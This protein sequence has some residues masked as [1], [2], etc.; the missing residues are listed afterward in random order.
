M[1]GGEDMKRIVM[2]HG[3]MLLFLA[4]VLTMVIM[5]GASIKVQAAAKRYVKSLSVK[6]NVTVEKGKKVTVKPT[7]KVAGKA[8]KKV[9]VKS[10]NKNIV[11][12]SYS[13]KNNTIKINGVKKGKATIAVTTKSKNKKG[14][15]ISKKINVKVTTET[16]TTEIPISKFILNKTAETLLIEH[17]NIV[18]D[19]VRDN[20]S[21]F[22]SNNNSNTNA[23]IAPAY[24]WFSNN[25]SDKVLNLI[26]MGYPNNTTEDKTITWISSNPAIAT[27]DGNGGV[28]PVSVGTCTIT[29][30]CGSHTADCVVTVGDDNLA[31]IVNKDSGWKDYLVSY[32]KVQSHEE[33]VTDDGGYTYRTETIIDSVSSNTITI[34]YKQDYDTE[35][36]KY[37]NQWW[38][39]VAVTSTMEVVDVNIQYPD[40]LIDEGDDLIG[41][42]PNMTF[43]LNTK[44]E[45]YHNILHRGFECN[46]TTEKC[47]EEHTLDSIKV[48]DSTSWTDIEY[49]PFDIN[50]SYDIT[51]EKYF[52]TEIE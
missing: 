22:K 9:T 8:S 19:S 38:L 18:F 14:K 27:V 15:R 2:K 31:N 30:K 50:K 11:K 20:S 46:G 23:S 13:A 34:K 10:S 1:I 37:D 40:I 5:G 47:K 29:A 52:C 6:K 51:S 48:G 35:L 25:L 41:W 21:Y 49:T 32:D 43:I 26:A 33:Q 36:I 7:V 39:G 3:F 12:V 28:T 44:Y 42:W 24:G 17:K 45:I 4:M 16:A